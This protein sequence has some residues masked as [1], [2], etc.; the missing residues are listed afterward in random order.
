MLYRPTDEYNFAELC[1]LHHQHVTPVAF[2]RK[3]DSQPITKQSRPG[4]AFNKWRAAH[5]NGCT[6][7]GKRQWKQHYA[8]IWLAKSAI[9]H[10]PLR[11]GTGWSRKSGAERNTFAEKDSCGREQRPQPPLPR[12]FSLS[13]LALAHT[14][15]RAAGREIK[16]PRPF[17]LSLRS[18]LH[19]ESLGAGVAFIHT[20]QLVL[21]QTHSPSERERN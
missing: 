10:S 14:L 1:N 3:I 18:L 16:E 21:P 8:L 5:F 19:V 12:H 9:A 2:T 11:T 20:I 15:S 13:F 17:L 7:A 6:R 4:V